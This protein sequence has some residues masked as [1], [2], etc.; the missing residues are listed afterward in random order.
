M[1][2]RQLTERRRIALDGDGR[3]GA[4]RPTLTSSPARLHPGGD[5]MTGVI[6]V[7]NARLRTGHIEARLGSN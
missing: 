5:S 1:C 3:E 4:Q 6:S 2:R 7:S